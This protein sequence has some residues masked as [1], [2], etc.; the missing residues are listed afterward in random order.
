MHLRTVVAA[1]CS[2][3]SSVAVPYPDVPASQVDMDL[4]LGFHWEIHRN[5]DSWA[6]GGIAVAVAVA[7]EAAIALGLVVGSAAVP[8]AVHIVVSRAV[9]HSDVYWRLRLVEEGSVVAGAREETRAAAGRIAHREGARSIVV[10]VVA[11]LLH[12]RRTSTK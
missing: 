6:V 5:L 8:A 9:V 11:D 1:V 12:V 7:A 10:V 4:R 3:G 2:A